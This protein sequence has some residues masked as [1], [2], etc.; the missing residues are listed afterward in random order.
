[1]K[2]RK[3]KWANVKIKDCCEILDNLRKPISAIERDELRIK[4][5]KNFTLTMV[6]QV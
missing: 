2:L 5:R 1:M 6:Q 4:S 3:D